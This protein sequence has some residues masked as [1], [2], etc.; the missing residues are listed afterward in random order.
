MK[1]LFSRSLDLVHALRQRSSFLFGPRGTGK[2]TWIRDSL[3]GARIYDLLDDRVYLQLVQKPSILEE[4]WRID[5]TAIIVLDEI[6]KLPKILDEVHRLITLHEAKFLLTGSS[7]RKLKRSG[8]N[9]LGGRARELHF[10]P[11]AFH[12]IPNCD[13]V[14]YLN[15]GGLP[16]VALSEEPL[17]DLRSYTNLYLREEIAAEALTRRVENFARFL[18]VIAVHSGEELHYQNFAS[19]AGIP[20]KTLQSYV[21]ILEDTLIGFRVNPFQKT[22]KRK[23]IARSKFYLFDLGVTRS[24]AKRGEVLPGSE[25]FG[26]AFEQFLALEMRAAISILDS[27]TALSYWRTKSGFEVDFV[28]GDS[29]AIESKAVPLVHE[30]HMKG[31]RALREENI[32]K[33][34]LVVSCD[35]SRRRT[36]D[37]ID[38]IPWQ[39]FLTDLWSG[40]YFE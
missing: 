4:E 2:S 21:E 16:L 8:V 18:D 39:E 23:A 13:L 30:N 15:R 9:L 3:K 1:E 33:K 19:D 25:L 28:L 20:V 22:I 37:G 34:A 32:V 26:K 29:I 31:L 17:K 7:A 14:T 10:F 40:K 27:D 35:P 24:L 5:P 6:Q 11:L 38:I 12:E 36:A